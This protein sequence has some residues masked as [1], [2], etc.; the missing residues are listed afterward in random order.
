MLTRTNA[1]NGVSW[2]PSRLTQTRAEPPSREDKEDQS[3]DTGTGRGQA[4]GDQKNVPT[5][6]KL[7][8]A[9][10]EVPLALFFSR[11]LPRQGLE[12]SGQDYLKQITLS[13]ED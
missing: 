12:Q 8:M 2:F 7:Q 5:V 11:K 3:R 4:N 10:R 6:G 9:T 1:N 13:T